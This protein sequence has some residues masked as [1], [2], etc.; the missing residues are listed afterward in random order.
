VVFFTLLDGL[1]SRMV[2]RTDVCVFGGNN[3]FETVAVIAMLIDGSDA[4][5]GARCSWRTRRLNVAD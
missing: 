4:I 5:A 3:S 1:R 2:P